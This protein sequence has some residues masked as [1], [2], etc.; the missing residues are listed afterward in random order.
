MA[1]YVK[2]PPPRALTQNETLDSLDHWKSIFKSYFRRDSVFKQFLESGCK[3]DPAL[4]NYELK[5]KDGMLAQD[6]KDALV[7]FLHNLAGFLPHSYLTSKLVKETKNLNDCW[8]IIE[9]HYNVKV[10]PETFLDFESL[11]KNPEEN[12]RQFYERLLQHSKLHLAPEDAKVES[13]V[14]A[15]QD[16]MS[17]SLMNHIA[18]QWL[19]KIDPQL[20]QIVRTEYATDLRSP[21]HLAALVPKIAPNIDS[22][23]SRYASSTVA[24]VSSNSETP[25]DDTK[26]G[27]SE[28]IRWVNTRGRGGQRFLRGGRGGRGGRGVPTNRS[29]QFCVGCFALGKQLDMFIPFKHKP[30][31][32][33]RQG[34]VARM[35]QTEDENDTG[36][37]DEDFYDD[38]G[39]RN[40]SHSIEKNA[41]NDL[42]N[43][44]EHSKA[45]TKPSYDA[46]NGLPNIVLTINLNQNPGEINQSSHTFATGNQSV[47]VCKTE[48]PF[49]DITDLV[50]KIENIEKRR[51]LWS[52][53]N[54]RRKCSPMVSARLNTQPCTPTIDEGSEINCVD[55]AFA[56]KCKIAQIPTVCSA[57]A[58]GNGTMKL[59]GQ[60]MDNVVLIIDQPSTLI[61]WD[62]SKCVIVEN[63]GVDIL[64]G[65]P[66]KVD[67]HIET[68]PLQEILQTKDVNGKIVD[69]PYFKKKSGT[70]FVCRAVKNENLFPGESLIFDLPPH[71]YREEFVVIA[72]TRENEQDFVTPEVV[73]IDESKTVK[74]TN[75]KSV[76]VRIKKHS[77]IADITA[78]KTVDCNKICTEA[79][80][81]L[82]L[83]RPD[84]FEK[85]EVD[86]S[87]T[88]QILIDPDN[89]MTKTW[90]ERFRK[91][92]ESFTDVINPNPGRYNNYYGNVDCT[93]DFCSTP[94][95]S[96]KARLP[97]Y[98]SEKLK[99]MAEQMDKM[100]SMGV[101]A[102]PENVGVVPAF[103]VP[104][105]LVPKPEKGEWRVVSDFTPLNIHI[106]KFETISPGIEEAKRTIAKYKYN[107]EMDLSNY[108]WQGGMRK[109]DIQYL[110][111]PHPYKGLRVYTVEPQGLRNASEHSY[112]KLTR[113]FGDLR[114]ADKMTCMADGLY[115]V[116]NTL[117]D[118][119]K[120]FTEV[121]HRARKC[122]LTFKPKKI[123]IAP[124]DTV[125]FGWK[126]EGEGWRPLDHVISPL[127]RAEEPVT[128]K[129]LRSFIGSYKQ[130]TECIKDYAMLLSPLEKAVAGL[131]SADRIDWTTELSNNFKTAKKALENTETIFVPKPIDILEIFVDFSQDKKGIGGKMMIKRKEEDGSTDILL[132]GYFSCKLSVYQ[133]NWLPCE[134]EALG[135]KII[136]KH[137]APFIRENKNTTTVYTDNLPTVH[138]WRRMKTGAFSTSAR[139]ASFLTGLSALTVELVHKPGKEMTTSDYNSRHP[140]SCTNERCKIC[141]FA[142][143]MEKLGDAVTCAVKSITANDVENGSIKMPF[144]QRPAWKTIQ[145]NDNAHRMLL[146]NIQNS[147]LPERKKTKGVF[148]TVKRLHNMYR[149]GQAKVDSDG[150]LTIKH[151]DAAGNN[152][153]A[154][155]VPTNFYPGLVNALHIKLNH[156]SKTQMQR[157]MSRHFY[158]TG[159]ARIIEEIT[160]A[161][162]VCASLK[163]L[164]KELFSQSTSTNPTFGEH[165]SADVIKKDG[166]LIFLC[167]EKLSQ[168]T[169]TRLIADET[170]DSLRDSIVAAVIDMIPE[171]GATVQVDC[172]PGLQKLAAEAKLDGSILKKLG[173]IIDLGRVHNIN[174]NPVAENAIKEFHKERLRLKPSGGKINEIERSIITKNMNS[175]VRERGLTS[176]EMAFNRDQIT[177]Q[178]KPCN[179]KILSEKQT[180]ARISRHPKIASDDDIVV[181][182][183]DNVFLKSDKSKLRGREV[184]KVT[185]LFQKN[186]EQWAT[187]QKCETKFMSKQYEVKISEIF[188][189]P[190]NKVLIDI[191]NKDEAQDDE[192]D[193]KVSQAPLDNPVEISENP[194][195]DLHNKKASSSEMILDDVNNKKGISTN[196]E[197]STN[198]TFEEVNI[199]KRRPKRKAAEKFNSKMKELLSCLHTEISLSRKPPTHG[200]YY[201]DWIVQI[202][203][204]PYYKEQ[205]I[206]LNDDIQSEDEHEEVFD[207][208]I[209]NSAHI[210]EECLINE[211]NLVVPELE[212]VFANQL[213]V[214]ANDPVLSDEDTF[215]KSESTAEESEPETP[216]GQ[217][218]RNLDDL[219]YQPARTSHGFSPM[220]MLGMFP[221]NEEPDDEEVEMTWD[222]STTPPALRKIT[223]EEIDDQLNSALVQ[224]ELYSDESLAIDDLTSQNSDDVFFDESILEVTI[225]GKRKFSR[226]NPLRKQ[227]NPRKND[228]LDVTSTDAD[229][230]NEETGEDNRPEETTDDDN[231]NPRTHQRPRRNVD[232]VDY[233]ILHRKGRK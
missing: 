182:V 47:N 123:V 59:T 192:E 91:T 154:I 136:C 62:L 166:Q 208:Q 55:S 14:N 222:N 220:G 163:E 5:D 184:Y 83:K 58:A 126:K 231:S 232:K 122:G 114:Q 172:A 88:D 29:Q 57:K 13:L 86:K 180:D 17:I 15:K 71:L 174:K 60:T 171:T 65:E 186:G 155:S 152:Y 7:D 213:T 209:E 229:D 76:P 70:R 40:I 73:K 144:L 187:I 137:F 162:T 77:S 221:P 189:A 79:K 54:I 21:Q 95:P 168:Y 41:F 104:S 110:A 223:D 106:R 219:A 80:D 19:R 10:T 233:A 16:E 215:N 52:E 50:R 11:K 132:G 90:K 210:D 160:A 72:P 149:T 93:I 167:R 150:F 8:K 177:N 230:E 12:Y 135:V 117:D 128:A 161:C 190:K 159:Q 127:T 28:Q 196:K 130:L 181:N 68:K 48:S 69:V 116:G 198:E 63:L 151:T 38:N 6:R 112:E 211:A 204:D 165:F 107:I 125:L 228:Q 145:S 157:L 4:A 42:Q 169:F 37:I 129:Q 142:Y 178:V 216:F 101:L 138:A 108:F 153:D 22:L 36:E 202:D 113:I 133:K 201:E 20:I 34:A 45:E 203:D 120:T 31:E 97:N 131:E 49:S 94:P 124:R 111:T 53:N 87:Y 197:T 225:D 81:D 61:K 170:A 102:K 200:W 85:S 194:Q 74:I 199:S 1:T 217:L 39:K 35:L 207:I 82:H 98:S 105:L 179:D 27:E 84:I 185:N 32:C 148:T 64:I 75:M 24:R 193:E 43:D 33:T 188:I 115:V 109:E 191:S 89:Q 92:C 146:D 164:P 212:N 156:P 119:H 51:Y 118:L 121:L 66:G 147:K 206:F 158:C 140:N 139:V 18:L 9:E 25:D 26:M 134:G 23:L 227:L 44:S 173:L 103:V 218:L 141:K 176:K 175:R 226:S 183:G 205:T 96:V 224:N 2:L 214:V 56:M 78:M 30:E 195:E 143:E 99:I 46:T 67:N 3:W 100:E